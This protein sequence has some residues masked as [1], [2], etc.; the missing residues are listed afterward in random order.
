MSKSIKQVF[1]VVA[2]MAA[3]MTGALPAFAEE[4]PPCGLGYRLGPLSS[5]PK[6]REVLPANEPGQFV[7]WRMEQAGGGAEFAEG[8]VDVLAACGAQPSV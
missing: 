7:L 1:A 2:A 4:N 3:L 8:F 6:N 5:D